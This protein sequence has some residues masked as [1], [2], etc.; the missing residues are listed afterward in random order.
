M[1]HPLH[2]MLVHFPLACWSLASI[3]DLA[4]GRYGEPAWHLAA[5]LMAIGVVMAVP[6]IVAG[7]IELIQVPDEGAA[8]RDAYLHMGVMMLAFALY[9]ASLMMRIDDR[10]FVAP[11]QAAVV[12]SVGGFITLMI[13]GWLGGR[14]VYGHG[15]GTSRN[16]DTEA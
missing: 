15:I 4:S 6:T 1:R 9:T 14:L 11:G 8:M 16:S 10:H 5:T 2:P 7:I 3:G 13:G 12:V